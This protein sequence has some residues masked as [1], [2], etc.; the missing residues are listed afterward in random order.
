MHAG[1]ANT[2]PTPT[3][4]LQKWTAV[5]LLA[6][7]P[8]PAGAAF[9]D[10]SFAPHLSGWNWN[11][12]DPVLVVTFFLAGLLSG[13]LFFAWLMARRRAS[14]AV[15][16]ARDLQ[17]ELDEAGAIM[18][19]EPHFL[20]IWH[21]K[22]VRPSRIVGDLRAIAGV[23]GDYESRVNFAGMDRPSLSRPIE[24]RDRRTAR[25]GHALQHGRSNQGRR[26]VGS[27]RA[28]CRRHGDV[29]TAHADR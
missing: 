15:V 28:R 3:R 25:S 7:W 24:R 29:E 20:Y 22:E 11:N 27:G 17:A 19:A 12:A 14:H 26:H 10:F 23:P 6:F 21:G 1:R 18:A 9:S 13:T 4:S 5:G 8:A 16:L 2:E